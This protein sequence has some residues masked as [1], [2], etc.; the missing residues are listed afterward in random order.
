RLPRPGDDRPRPGA[1]R[2]H[3]HAADEH[4]GGT[5]RTSTLAARSRAA[6]ASDAATAYCLGTPLRSEI[7]ARDKSRLG[8][9]S[10][11]ATQAIAARFGPGPVDSKIQAHIVSI[12]R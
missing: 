3:R 12:E 5:P 4:A 10:D 8:A 7:E 11:A 1:R 2:L 9:A 6:S